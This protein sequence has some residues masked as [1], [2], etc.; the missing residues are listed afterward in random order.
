MPE[1]PEVESV[2]RSLEPLCGTLVTGVQAHRPEVVG[3]AKLTR[4]GTR[5]DGSRRARGLDLPPDSLQ[6]HLLLGRTIT[7]LRRRG[8]V[9]LLTT[10]TTKGLA[11]HLGMT[12]ELVLTPPSANGRGE[13]SPRPHTHVT[14]S[15]ASASA[16]ATSQP[17][18]TLRFCDPRRFGGVL[19]V[20]DASAPSPSCWAGLGP[21]AL[22]TDPATLA[23]HLARVGHASRRCVKALVLDQHT[24][25]GVG[26][27]YADEACFHARIPPAARCTSLRER[28]WHALASA[29]HTV[30]S[31]AVAAGGSTVR[32]YVNAAGE[33]GQF[34]AQHLVYGRAGEPCHA[35]E[36]P[37]TAK[38]LAGRATV[39][40][41]S[42]QR[43][44]A[45]PPQILPT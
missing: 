20:P 26:N 36:R 43:L 28:H 30:L 37:L 24:L 39:W 34:A 38:R 8:K 29:V 27:I 18:H 32:S 19:I 33:P 45:H 15:L 21:D 11:F 7:T 13:V 10:D 25:A 3:L 12:G 5:S 1:L 41:R 35:C 6:Q 23:Q 9:L 44:H 16:S 42:C 2:R 31:R 4:A 14:W 22:D 40:C 17:G